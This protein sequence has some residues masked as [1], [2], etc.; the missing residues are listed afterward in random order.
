VRIPSNIAEEKLP[1]HLLN[2]ENEE[3][4]MKTKDIYKEL[5]L[6]GYQYAGLFRGLKSSSITGKQ[7]HITWM[8]NWVVFLDSMLQMK[9]LGMDTRNLY[10][11]TSIQ[12]LVIDAKN[13]AQYVRNTTDNRKS[14][15][16][17]FFLAAF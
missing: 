1:S 3:E 14:V 4:V 16:L 15:D 17:F 10:V 6:R 12:K 13:H 11:P 8:Y 7:G 2:Q 5:R 9:I